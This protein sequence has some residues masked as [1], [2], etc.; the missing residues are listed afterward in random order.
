MKLIR[1]LW[2]NH[3]I[4]ELIHRI[5]TEGYEMLVLRCVE[6][7][8]EYYKSYGVEVKNNDN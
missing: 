4:N 7:D 1:R 3:S 5:N 8:K 6:C 2:C